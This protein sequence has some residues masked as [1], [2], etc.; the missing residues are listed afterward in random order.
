MN[1]GRG[2]ERRKGG[3]EKLVPSINRFNSVCWLGVPSG[4]F[5]LFCAPFVSLLL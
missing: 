5:V 3:R 4:S 1:G 2:S